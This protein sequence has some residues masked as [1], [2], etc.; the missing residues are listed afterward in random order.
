MLPQLVLKE[1]LVRLLDVLRQVAE[2]RERRESGWQLGH[3]LDLHILALPGRR[4]VILDLRQH[5]LVQPCRRKLAG[6]VLV[7]VLGLI[8]HIHDSLFPG[9][10][11]EY[12]R[13][14]IERSDAAAQRGF[15]FL[16]RVAVLQEEVPFVD[17]QHAGLAVA[18]DEVEYA[19]V[20]SLHSGV[21]V[22]HQDADIGM[23]DC[24]DGTHHGVELQILVDLGFPAHSGGVHEHKLV[25]E[26]VVE[27]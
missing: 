26:L 4:R 11:G 12:D 22:D 20:L 2:E 3:V 6:I 25:P 15:I 18:D 7:N 10:R 5:S 24:P 14:V 21:R 16:H 19:H 27:G 13:H 1:S 17:H 23:F 8:Q 9:D